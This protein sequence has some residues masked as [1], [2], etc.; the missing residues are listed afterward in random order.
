MTRRD[1]RPAASTQAEP[2]GEQLQRTHGPALTDTAGRADAADTE[3][4]PT[5]PASRRPP[6]LGR[7]R[8]EI[9][10]RYI[11]LSEL[12]RGGM[13]VVW[14]AHDPELDRRVALK[15][16][17]RGA[18]SERLLREAQALARLTHPNVVAVYDAGELSGEVWLAM[19]LV[20]GVTLKTWLKRHP[21]APAWHDVLTLLIPAG[22]GVAAAHHA[23]L[24]HRDLKPDN[25]MIGADGRARVMD[26]GLARAGEAGTEPVADAGL[27]D[28]PLVSRSSLL[29]SDVTRAGA[30]VGTPAYM[31]PEQFSGHADERADVFAF[32]VLL[33]EAL[34]GERPFAG[35]TPPAIL[36]SITLGRIHTPHG[37]RAPRWLRRVLLRG[38]AADIDVRWPTMSALIAAIKRGRARARTLK[39]V[40]LLGLLALLAAAALLVH[41]LDRAQTRAMCAATG[42]E[43]E[44]LWPGRAAAARAGLSRSGVPS[45]D[46]TF[47]RITPWLDRWSASWSRARADACVAAELDLT[48][49][50][51]LASRVTTCL[52]LQR[53]S[54]DALL[55][56]LADGD[57]TAAATAISFAASLRGSERCLDRRVL[58]QT[59]WPPPERRAELD[60]LRARQ[61]EL[62]TT[63]ALGQLDRAMSDAIALLAEAEALGWS[64]AIAEADYMLG[65]LH[66]RKSNYPDAEAA[67]RR[68][69]F[70]AGRDG[71]HR[72][73]ATAAAELV[74]VIGHELA[75]P[76]EGREWG[77]HAAMHLGRL[78]E[79]EQLS[80]ANLLGNLSVIE[81]DLGAP[82]RAVELAERALAIETAALGDDHIILAGTLNNLALALAA[83]GRHREARPHL[84]RALALREATLGP[85]HYVVASSLHNLAMN[86]AR[87]DEPEQALLLYQ[88]ALAV[89]E[90]NGEGDGPRA[91]NTYNTMLPIH[92]EAG[93]TDEAIRVGERALEIRER[94]LGPDHPAVGAALNNLA[95]ALTAAG[96]ID[97]ALAHHQ[98]A[99]GLRER[100]LGP[101]HP[102]IARSLTNIAELHER[103]HQLRLATPLLERALKI[104]TDAA[105]APQDRA[106]TQFALGRV[107]HASGEQVRGHALVRAAA[108]AWRAA[109]D[110]R[111]LEADAWLNDHPAAPGRRAKRRTSTARKITP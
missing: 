60:L 66:A 89:I 20:D 26:F 74:L 55:Q 58:D 86:L 45:P 79:E 99:L 35:D 82:E 77:E 36:L 32:S 111:A 103:R 16:L 98:R 67:L 3:H 42:A 78:G 81:Q 43:I 9:I 24:V 93:R 106:Y 80:G 64:P 92:L 30:L 37:R 22:E 109:A 14:A 72:L 12:G 4:V 95:L 5:E 75:R 21:R 84:E 100:A 63:R 54:V 38:L 71:D 91:A 51:E 108:E 29:A 13:G 47:A 23:G 52:D 70:R 88:R 102:D 62:N 15:L 7:S 33:W 90:A 40:A 76:K 56:R 105:V 8:G 44:A 107:L 49:D 110:K 69:Y 11:L 1:G 87:L 28:D 65:S 39:F 31:A 48:I 94:T 57:P 104:R 17:T 19:E 61:S 68:A 83:L 101:D 59:L 34:Y 6:R 41:A 97:R 53:G 2:L 27:S 25:I 18:S 50:A 85:T 73:A 10:G 96:A 46:D